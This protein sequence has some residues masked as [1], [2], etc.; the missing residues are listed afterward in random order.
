MFINCKL[1]T[2]L[3]LSNF[4][5]SNMDDMHDLFDNCENL[6]YLNLEKFNKIVLKANHHIFDNVPDNIFACGN[7]SV[8]SNQIK[9]SKNVIQ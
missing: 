2:S 1:L 9:N 4:N 8:I 3:N 6:I 7:V 5:T